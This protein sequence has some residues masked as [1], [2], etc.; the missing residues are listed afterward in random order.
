[1]PSVRAVLFA[2]LTVPLLLAGTAVHASEQLGH[3]FMALTAAEGAPEPL[4]SVLLSN[5]A[6]TSSR[7]RQGEPSSPAAIA[8][9]TNVSPSISSPPLQ[10]D[11]WHRG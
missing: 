4:R 1:M 7:W 11:L 9:I 8:S 5:V 10:R 6:G 3:L 2:C